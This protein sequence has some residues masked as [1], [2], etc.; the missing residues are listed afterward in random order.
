MVLALIQQANRMEIGV[1]R[2]LRT[3][4]E[5]WGL[6]GRCARLGQTRNS[7]EAGALQV[8]DCSTSR[9]HFSAEHGMLLSILPLDSRCRS[10]I[11]FARPSVVPQIHY[12]SLCFLRWFCYVCLFPG[13]GMLCLDSRDMPW[14]LSD[15]VSWLPM[16]RLSGLTTCSSLLGSCSAIHVKLSLDS[17]LPHLVKCP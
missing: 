10:C 1:D 8:C 17:K 2:V 6:P 16:L 3:S 4:E 13:C 9:T 7:N 12:P 5:A 14:E 15:L 11:G